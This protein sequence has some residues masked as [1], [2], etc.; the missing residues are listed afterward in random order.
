MKVDLRYR[1]RS[2]VYR[3]AGA[4]T[5]SL[6]A[7]LAR[8]PVAFDATLRNPIPF[9]EAMSALHE[10]VVSDH[11]FKKKDKRAYEAWKKSQRDEEAQLR[12]EAFEEAQQ[13]VRPAGPPPEDLDRRFRKMHRKY[14][15]ARWKWADELLRNDPELWRHLMPCDPV[16]TVAPDVVLFEGFAKDESSYGC[17]QVDRDVFVGKQEARLGTT[18]VDYSRALYDH[19]Q[20]LRTYRDT[21][22]AVDPEGVTVTG[23]VGAV[24][25]EKIDLPPSWL[26]AFGQ[27]SAA[28]SL[29]AT[30][31][32]LP[33]ET[34]YS[35][36]AYLRRRREKHG[37]RSLRFELS[38]GRAPTIAIE[39]WDELV[40]SRG[41][42]WAGAS[43]RTIKVWGRRRLGVLARV[44]PLAERV[45]VHLLG[46]GLPSLWVAHLGPI[47]FVLGV[48]G[49]T[50][51]DFAGGAQLD[52]L[53][54]HY[55]A[56]PTLVATLGSL[57]GQRRSETLAGLREAT[58]S[59]DADLLGALHF[60]AKR[61]QTVFDFAHGVYRY[62][63]ILG[64]ALGDSLLGPEPEELVEGRR[65]FVDNRV[66][67]S[68]QESLDRGRQLL[69]ARI[70]G[71][72]CEAILDGDGV[73][74]KGRCPCGHH[75]RFGL[76]K[77][78]C[79]HL[80]ALRLSATVASSPIV[81]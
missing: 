8:E 23:E 12:R 20:T 32:E 81:H 78:P 66:M 56:D 77:G 48:S 50:T 34:V 27:I 26:R 18:N 80:L 39:P 59:T 28:T 14:W 38:P 2:S 11:R 6:A 10:V 51:N 49:W 44:L 53:A 5:V 79:R 46:S 1:G 4:A 54:G 31:V 65:L 7:N 71:H 13:E 37:P 30:V 52:L 42:A 70:A 74:Q 67:V 22:L 68:R 21:R 63:P 55:R 25:E 17:V 41:N 75:R 9:R 35:I 69:V 45:E 62:R 3:T 47:R 43:K 73:F 76:R 16:V 36:L 15:N 24:R 33:V 61:G 58:G 29:P 57:L 19:F 40:V 72:D 60:L 64:V